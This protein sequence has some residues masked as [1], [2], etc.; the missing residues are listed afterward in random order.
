MPS[1]DQT[2]TV[3]TNNYLWVSESVNMTTPAPTSVPLE[4][5]DILPQYLLILSILS[6]KCKD[7]A[8]KDDK[9]VQ[10]CAALTLATTKYREFVS[11]L[12]AILPDVN[13]LANLDTWEF[14]AMRTSILSPS[15]YKTA[16]KTF[17]RLNHV[18]DEVLEGDN[19]FGNFYNKENQQRR[20]DRIK[21]RDELIFTEEEFILQ[22]FTLLEQVR[23]TRQENVTKHRHLKIF[24]IVALIPQILML[25]LVVA[26]YLLLKKRARAAKKRTERHN[27][28]QQL[29]GRLIEIRGPEARPLE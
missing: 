22:Q 15:A 19:F 18:S 1:R 4:P 10:A 21:G 6:T 20:D 2:K 29:L 12:G 7:V 23:L 25:I 24:V 13:T 5:L 27:R 11:P 16:L 8:G 28:E 14:Q 9:I 3:P 17:Q 26:Q